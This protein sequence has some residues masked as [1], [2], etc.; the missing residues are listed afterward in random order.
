MAIEGML[1]IVFPARAD[2]AKESSSYVIAVQFKDGAGTLQAPTAL[3]WNLSSRD[4]SIVSDRE[5]VQVESPG[6]ENSI[7]L[8][9]SDLNIDV[10][11]NRRY[12]TVS[13]KFN[14]SDYGDGLFVTAEEKFDIKNLIGGIPV[15]DQT[16][17]AVTVL[18]DDTTL[19]DTTELTDA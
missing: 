12:L 16:G 1:A 6:S 7:I 19:T 3:A 18:N 14:S 11:G 5:N 9:A 15:I 4:G 2:I 10:D 13:A 17:P 8:K